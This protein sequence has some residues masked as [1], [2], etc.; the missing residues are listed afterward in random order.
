MCESA[1]G[2][3]LLLLSKSTERSGR[4]SEPGWRGRAGGRTYRFVRPAIK[5]DVAP[6]LLSTHTRSLSVCECVIALTPIYSNLITRTRGGAPADGLG[7]IALCA[8]GAL[9]NLSLPA[10][11]RETSRRTTNNKWFYVAGACVSSIITSKQNAPGSSQLPC[12]LLKCLVALL[13]KQLVWF[14]GFNISNLCPLHYL[15]F[16]RLF[17]SI[18]I[19]RLRL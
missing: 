5:S 19:V 17:G 7:E 13:A 18:F 3:R 11:I 16:I 6:T 8:A 12:K 4:R 15:L 2:G 1:S 9:K 10:T 14:N